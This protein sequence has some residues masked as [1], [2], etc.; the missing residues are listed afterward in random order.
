MFGVRWVQLLIIISLLIIEFLL[1]QIL[2]FIFQ[3]IPYHLVMR[4]WMKHTIIP[5]DPDMEMSTKEL[6]T[7]KGYPVE[8]HFVLTE[9]GFFL[10]LQRIP[11]GPTSTLTNGKHSATEYTFENEF[12]VTKSDSIALPSNRKRPVVLII[13]GF[14]QNSEALVARKK[15]EHN[16]PMVLVNAGFDVWLGNNRGN[17]YSHKHK[18]LKPTDENFWDFSLDELILFDVPAMITY[19][20]KCTESEKISVIGFSQGS[21]QIFGTLSHFPELS[22]RVHLFVALSPATRVRGLSFHTLVDALIRSRPESIFYMFG[23]KAFIPSTLFWR[24]KLSR[25]RYVKIIDGMLSWIFGWRT[26]NLAPEEKPLLYAHIYSYTSVKIVVHWFQIMRTNKFQMFDDYQTANGDE[27]IGHVLP[28]YQTSQIRCPIA[29]FSGG[30]DMLPNLKAILE[31][32]PQPNVVYTHIEPNY[33]HLDFIWGRDAK[34]KI[35]P[36]LINLLVKYSKNEVST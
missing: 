25:Y 15:A 29:L 35:F 12:S 18:T 34:E 21:A 27:Y 9:D 10:G 7:S 3:L 17:K 2:G 20:L 13:H 26:Q 5:E 4:F 8:E 16:L 11:Y 31:N 6:I 36:K 14:C 19:I 23:R 24:R 28:E 22:K 32:L 30:C 33:E 1:R